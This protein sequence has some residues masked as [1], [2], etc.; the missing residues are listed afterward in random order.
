L[1]QFVVDDLNNLFDLNSDFEVMRYI[2]GGLPTSYHDI[3]KNKT[4]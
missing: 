1:R 3:E 2:N 4:E